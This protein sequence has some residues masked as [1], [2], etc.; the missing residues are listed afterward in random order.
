MQHWKITKTEQHVKEHPL[1]H[2]VK[3][4]VLGPSTTWKN[5]SKQADAIFFARRH[6]SGCMV[7]SYEGEAVIAESDDNISESDNIVQGNVINTLTELCVAQ[8]F[9]TVNQ[10]QNFSPMDVT[11][12]RKDNSIHL[13]FLMKSHHL[14]L[15]TKEI[16][17][18]C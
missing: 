2:Y 15:K 4:T 3:P 9:F 5:F 8:T 7:W 1:P 14:H 17:T 18:A 10:L 13:L 16:I 12:L 6:G 11:D